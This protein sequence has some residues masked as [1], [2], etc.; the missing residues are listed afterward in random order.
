MYFPESIFI[1]TSQ[2]KFSINQ[3]NPG[4]PGKIKPVC[5]RYNHLADIT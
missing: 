3:Q 5:L 1:W 4:E 2:F